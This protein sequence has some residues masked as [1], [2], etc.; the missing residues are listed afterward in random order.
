[1]ASRSSS[2]ESRPLNSE[3][4]RLRNRDKNAF[5]RLQI[6]SSQLSELARSCVVTINKRK[7]KESR[8]PGKTTQKPS[9]VVK[10]VSIESRMREYKNVEPSCKSSGKTFCRE[11]LALKPALS[12]D[13][14]GFI[15]A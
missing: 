11:E 9:K 15:E 3:P 1:M 4:R 7:N 6:R 5:S 10:N 14:G 8:G 2:S 13:T 12:R